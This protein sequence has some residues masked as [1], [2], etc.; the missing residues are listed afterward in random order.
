M[1][2]AFL[3][4]PPLPF[5]SPFFSPCLRGFLFSPFLSIPQNHPPPSRFGPARFPLLPSLLAT[6]SA[7]SSSSSLGQHSTLICS[8]IPVLTFFF[9]YPLPGALALGF[10]MIVFARF[11]GVP[12]GPGFS[13][14]DYFLS[15]ICN[16]S[17]Q[18][19]AHRSSPS[20]GSRSFFFFVP[21]VVL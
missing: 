16:P 21:L 19:W 11:C 20:L 17:F 12:L 15:P 2:L 7:P 18:L 3:C 8:G 6:R 1:K 9:F 5:G 10:A 14:P 13:P 4:N